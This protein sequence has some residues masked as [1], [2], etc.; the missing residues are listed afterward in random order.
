VA[1]WIINIEEGANPG[2]PAK[3]IPQLQTPG[4][5]GEAFASSGDMVNWFNGTSAAHKPE[6]TTDSTF[7]T[8]VNAARQ[9]TFYLSDQIP[10]GTTSRPGWIATKPNANPPFPT[11]GNTLFYRCKLHPEEHGMIIVS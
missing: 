4:P 11:P 3:F 9:T 2:D 8:P 1:T 7:G 6:A 10:K 5:N